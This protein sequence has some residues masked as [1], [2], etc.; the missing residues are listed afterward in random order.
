MTVIEAVSLLIG[1]LGIVIAVYATIPVYVLRDRGNGPRWAMTSR[2]LWAAL[3][4][5]LTEN[6]AYRLVRPITSRCRALP[7]VRANPRL[8]VK[9]ARLYV[10]RRQLK[11]FAE[12]AVGGFEDSPRARAPRPGVARFFNLWYDDGG[13]QRLTDKEWSAI[14]RDV[15][16][17]RPELIALPTSFALNA[18]EDEPPKIEAYFDALQAAQTSIGDLITTADFGPID[19]FL[20]PVYVE[21]GFA[22]PLFLLRGLVRRFDENWPL[23][24]QSYEK[25]CAAPRDDPRASHVGEY[26]QKVQTFTFYCWLLWGPS[27]PI[28]TCKAWDVGTISIGQYGYGDEA[29]SFPLYFDA[30]PSEL[31]REPLVATIVGRLE[32]ES[33][34]VPLAVQ[35]LI[36]AELYWGPAHAA[37]SKIV[38]SHQDSV[39][40]EKIVDENGRTQHVPRF[41]GLVLRA[42][43]E[44]GHTVDPQPLPYYSAYIWAMIE[45]CDETGAPLPSGDGRWRNLLPVFE[46]GNIADGETASA[47]KQVLVGK[48]LST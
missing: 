28:C 20:T 23:L 1:V 6:E 47:S 36:D 5:H 7:H 37:F 12:R 43:H 40:V 24:L 44:D 38:R 17:P 10:E 41:G 21:T 11:K 3:Y 25:D 22:A 18:L 27:V 16:Q 30:K 34:K 31:A 45:L 4:P 2:M 19:R 39:Y 8:L 13:A 29:N 9:A 48:V 32:S 26:T 42:L 15:D 35:T 33:G 46:H 14:D